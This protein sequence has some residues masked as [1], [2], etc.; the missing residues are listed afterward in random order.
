MSCF[1]A[2]RPCSKGWFKRMTKKL[3]A[4]ASPTMIIMVGCF[5][6]R[7]SIGWELEVLACSSQLI[8]AAVDLDGEFNDLAHQSTTTRR[9]TLPM[10]IASSNLRLVRWM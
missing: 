10:T 1:Q 7:E 9:T 6:Q 4:L 5:S 3:T 8:L 2:A